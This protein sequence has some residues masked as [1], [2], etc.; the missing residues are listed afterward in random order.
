[1]TAPQPRA[2]RLVSI[3]QAAGFGTQEEIVDTWI[4][5]L[6]GSAVKTKL[7]LIAFH[8]GELARNASAVN[9]LRKLGR[10]LAAA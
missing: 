9:K 6:G 8:R 3:A 7:R 4:R 5:R 1:M 2:G 10:A